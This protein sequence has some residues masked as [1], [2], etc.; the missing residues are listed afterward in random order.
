[1]PRARSWS[2]RPALPGK[3][4]PQLVVVERRQLP[5]RLETRPAQPLLGSGPDAGQP[6]DVEGSEERSFPPGRNDGQAAGLPQVA[7]HLGDD[8]ARR[9]AERARQ[10]RRAAHGRLHGLGDTSSLEEVGRDLAMSR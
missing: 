2:M 7:R 3:Q 10:A 8:L 5:D 9:D 1:M 4:A 6:P